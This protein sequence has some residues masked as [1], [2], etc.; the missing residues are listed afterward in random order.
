MLDINQ[1]KSNF[2]HIVH[3]ISCFE[4]YLDMEPLN[5]TYDSAINHT[6]TYIDL[7]HF[8]ITGCILTKNFWVLFCP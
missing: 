1:S 5:D 8:Y 7:L 3:L 4:A 6:F 2:N